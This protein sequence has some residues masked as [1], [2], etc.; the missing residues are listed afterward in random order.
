MVGFVLTPA[1]PLL[2]LGPVVMR[3]WLIVFALCVG[4]PALADALSDVRAREIDVQRLDGERG[5][6]EVR[7][8]RL[9]AESQRLAA[10]IDG[11]KAEPAGVG[12]DARLQDLLARQQ[13][14][15]D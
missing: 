2:R 10:Q 11:A 12:R 5:Q 13:V 6:L 3:T 1:Y 4:A 14:A 7:R 9:E 15:A 8:A